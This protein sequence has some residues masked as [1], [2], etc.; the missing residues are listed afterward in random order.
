MQPFYSAN[1][2]YGQL[3]V[4]ELMRKQNQA[5]ISERNTI[6]QTEQNFSIIFLFFFRLHFFWFV[7]LSRPVGGGNVLTTP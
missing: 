6:K 4:R 1:H 7:D 2:K 5:G 3:R